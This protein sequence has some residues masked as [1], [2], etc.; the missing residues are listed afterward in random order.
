MRKYE[1]SINR[2]F[3]RGKAEYKTCGLSSIFHES[4]EGK[5]PK[6]LIFEKCMYNLKRFITI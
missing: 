4:R 3:L 5:R 1:E 2:M 6:F